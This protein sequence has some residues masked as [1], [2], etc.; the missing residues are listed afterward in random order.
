M[1]LSTDQQLKNL[2]E[3]IAELAKVCR[4]G[5][6]DYIHPE[7]DCRYQGCDCKRYER[8]ICCD[9]ALE[10]LAREPEPEPAKCNLGTP[11]CVR[12][13]T[14]HVDP[15]CCCMAYQGDRGFCNSARADGRLCGCSD[16]SHTTH[17]KPIEVS[18]PGGQV[19]PDASTPE[20]AGLAAT[21]D[22]KLQ[23]ARDEVIEAATLYCRTNDGAH[24][25]RLLDAVDKLIAAEKEARK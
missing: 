24:Y 2:T 15:Q 25:R 11:G 17:T 1:T 14:E 19:K 3:A 21:K 23:A 7:L 9:T 13:G 16:E 8:N 4:C 12:I 6:D 5:H 20:P 18:Q 22:D 10:I